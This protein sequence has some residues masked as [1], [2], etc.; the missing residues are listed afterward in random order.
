M[1]RLAEA[2]GAQICSFLNVSVNTA[3]TQKMPG[4]PDAKS[5]QT[6]SAFTD[7]NKP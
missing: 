3:Q 2:T 1:P 7:T 6:A 4:F 5:V